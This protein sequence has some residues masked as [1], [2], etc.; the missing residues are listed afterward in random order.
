MLQFRSCTQLDNGLKAKA[1]ATLKW[2]VRHFRYSSDALLELLRKLKKVPR[3]LDPTEFRANS[4][5][6]RKEHFHFVKHP[7]CGILDEV[8]VQIKG[9]HTTFGFSMTTNGLTAGLLMNRFTTINEEEVAHDDQ[10]DRLQTVQKD[11]RNRPRRFSGREPNALVDA[12]QLRKPQ[13]V[14]PLQ[15]HG[16]RRRKNHFWTVFND[17]WCVREPDDEQIRRT[18]SAR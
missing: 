1:F 14:R 11:H 16:S 17:K 12:L 4:L 6:Y 3:G 15:Q 10:S 8:E 13:A 7:Q 18:R 9:E 5:K 2:G